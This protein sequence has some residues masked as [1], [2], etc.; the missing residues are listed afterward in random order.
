MKIHEKGAIISGGL[1][2]SQDVIAAGSEESN[3]A[4]SD[5]FTGGE[6]YEDSEED[7]YGSDISDSEIASTGA[8]AQPPT[9][10]QNQNSADG[11]SQNLPITSAAAPAQQQPPLTS[12][13]Q[14]E[15]VAS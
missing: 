15:G 7:D 6:E 10:T 1:I 3:T 8:G 9:S 5:S 2:K 12:V 14:S 11:M 13:G 4:F